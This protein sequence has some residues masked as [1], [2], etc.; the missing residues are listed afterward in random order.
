[1]GGAGMTT[2]PVG[3]P[4]TAAG[5]GVAVVVLEG[6]LQPALKITAARTSI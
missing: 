3:V 4:V 6:A 5:G 2:G 1:M